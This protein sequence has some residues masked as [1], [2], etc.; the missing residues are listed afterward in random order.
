MKK[1][2]IAAL[3]ISSLLF[4]G[5]KPAESE[6]TL[7]LDTLTPRFQEVVEFSYTTE[8]LKGYEYPMVLVSCSQGADLVYRQLDYPDSP[9]LILGS[10]SSLWVTLGGGDAECN[11]S[12]WAY[13]GLMA[14]KYERRLTE[15]LEFHAEG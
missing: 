5:A 10:G 8:K 1:S 4:F 13:P 3:V 12:L 9:Q 6:S 7:T 11:A 14:G 15:P 2:A